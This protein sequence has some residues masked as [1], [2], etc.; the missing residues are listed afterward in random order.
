MAKTP[1]A[2]ELTEKIEF[3]A[4]SQVDDGYGNT[5]SGP[6]ATQFTVRARRQFVRGSEKVIA[7]MQ[8]SVQPAIFTVRS[9]SE[10]RQ[11]TSAWQ[12]KDAR[13]GALYNIRAVEP[14]PDRRWIDLVVA[15]G[16]AA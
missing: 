5:V 2:G 10:T 4:R 16:E 13:S 1:S 12:V 3:Q 14:W 8:T 15:S 9:S 7:A 11:I 6:F